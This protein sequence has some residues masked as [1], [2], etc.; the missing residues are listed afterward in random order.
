MALRPL[1][2]ARRRGRA[3]LGAALVAVLALVAAC[4]DDG[5]EPSTG[6]A[7]GTPVAHERVEVTDA[8][9]G[10]FD[11]DPDDYGGPGTP[12]GAGLEVPEGALLQ[13]STFPDLVG[14]GYRALLL[15]VGDPVAVH[16]ALVDQ[17]RDLG[18][19]GSGGCIGSPEQIG[20]SG[21]FA[22]PADG[23]SL[24]FGL[25]RV[26]GPNGIVSGVGLQYRPP[27][28][29]DAPTA[30]EQPATP[31]TPFAEVVLPDP[32]P[33]P[34]P[35]DV[36]LALRAP[37]AP[38]R[39]VETGSTLVGLPG[40]CACDGP[41]WSFVV[42]LDGVERDIIAGYGRQF[43][44]LGDPPDMEDSHRADLTLVGLR[45]GE[46]AQVAEIRATLPDDGTPYAIV[47]VRTG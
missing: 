20:C 1:P 29:E 17:A 14:G 42:R 44:D 26:L 22:D 2:V 18:M 41:G 23:E 35:L 6:G 46:G 25:S 24:A 3:R 11:L 37:E 43:A 16:D 7:A 8:D 36:G 13:G 15:V 12:L 33:A 34:D 28:S 19:D 40:P 30:D 4:S 32:V 27:G 9:L 21:R 39:A 10:P 31:T 45:V 47:T 5:S 38:A